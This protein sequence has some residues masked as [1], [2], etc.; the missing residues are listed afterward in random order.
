[1]RLPRTPLITALL[2]LP[3][4]CG[5][6]TEPRVPTEMVVDRQSLTLERGDTAHVEARVL[7]QHGNVLGTLPQGMTLTW[8]TSN[9]DVV[10]VENGLVTA[11]G[12]GAARVTARAGELS[13]DVSVEVPAQFSN[14]L[15]FDYSGDRSGRFDVSSTFRISQRFP[16]QR[17]WAF[18]IYDA[19]HDDQDLI[20]LRTDGSTYDL[21]Y[22]WVDRRVTSTGSR[23]ANGILVFGQSFDDQEEYEALYWVSSGEV[24]FT[25]ADPFRLDGSFE[26]GMGH[27]DTGATLNLSDGSFSLPVMTDADFGSSSF[28][29]GP[30][31][32]VLDGPALR[33]RAAHL[34]SLLQR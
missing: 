30:R 2:V 4:A 26:I 20:A 5:D 13:A 10:S 18:S 33:E 14:Q 23:E 21:L 27:E 1:M 29:V 11:T 24:A 25:R 8:E 6:S 17:E 9:G 32:T 16:D 3:L 19:G 28:A 22:L 7:D 12:T 34:R 15:A 31:E